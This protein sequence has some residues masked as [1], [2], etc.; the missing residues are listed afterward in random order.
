MYNHAIKIIT[1]YIFEYMH[2]TALF[3]SEQIVEIK[4]ALSL[5]KQTIVTIQEFIELHQD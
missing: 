2:S 3:S 4:Q 5:I 1:E